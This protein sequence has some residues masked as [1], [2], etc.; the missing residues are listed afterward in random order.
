MAVIYELSAYR[1]PRLLNK[2]ARQAEGVVDKIHEHQVYLAQLEQAVSKLEDGLNETR[3]SLHDAEILL[4]EAHD[5]HDI[6]VAALRA[7]T[8]KDMVAARKTIMEKRAEQGG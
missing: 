4:E 1:T 2:F 8:I 7:G 3:A 6:S 5:V